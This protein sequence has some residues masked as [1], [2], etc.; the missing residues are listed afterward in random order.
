MTSS[1]MKHVERVEDRFKWENYLTN[2][3]LLA[4]AKLLN[5][6]Q[7]Q[8]KHQHRPNTHVHSYHSHHHHHHLHH[9]HHIHHNSHD[10]QNRSRKYSQDDMD[11]LLEKF[12]FA[13]HINRLSYTY[14]K[15]HEDITDSDVEEARDIENYL[16]P[17]DLA[18]KYFS[19]EY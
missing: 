8:N 14:G 5:L 13:K 1:Y 9:H 18:R 3:D 2:R 17:R 10:Y 11:D 4:K 6:V 12:A 15:F 16:V 7:H 19:H